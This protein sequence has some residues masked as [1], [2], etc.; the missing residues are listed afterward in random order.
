MSVVGNM[1]LRLAIAKYNFL[2]NKNGLF[3][4]ISCCWC[5]SDI[6]VTGW[7]EDGRRWVN[8]IQIF[9]F[10][11]FSFTFL[12]V[13]TSTSSKWG[14]LH[15]GLITMS[16]VHAMMFFFPLLWEVW[17]KMIPYKVIQDLSV[18]DGLSVQ[19]L[20]LRGPNNPCRFK[21]SGTLCTSCMIK[22]MIP[23]LNVKSWVLSQTSA[24]V[25][26]CCGVNAM[27]WPLSLIAY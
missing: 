13:C 9:G 10:S 19:C 15:F 24:P 27:L 3:H 14:F 21:H 12:M 8:C 18:V 11:C 6:F 2:R 22:E 20:W 1:L 5:C 17:M 26:P 16:R 7:M 4:N 25:E 23:C